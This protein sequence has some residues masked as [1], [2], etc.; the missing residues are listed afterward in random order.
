MKTVFNNFTFL[1]ND[2]RAL[3]QKYNLFFV[4]DCCSIKFSFVLSYL[5]L[6]IHMPK[7]LAVFPIKIERFVSR[8]F[9]VS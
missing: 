6:T 4:L 9:P 1:I 7:H 8:L 2:R 5:D 3:F